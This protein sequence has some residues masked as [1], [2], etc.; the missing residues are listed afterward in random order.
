MP[1]SYKIVQALWWFPEIPLPFGTL[2]STHLSRGAATV[3]SLGR[4]P[5]E[6]GRGSTQAPEGGQSGPGADLC[7]PSG[8]PLALFL[9]I[10][11]LTPSLFYTSPWRPHPPCVD[12][13]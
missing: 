1:A 9:H 6:N 11:G 8:A 3:S 12:G 2:V 5:Q 10:L 4:E 13:E 7:R